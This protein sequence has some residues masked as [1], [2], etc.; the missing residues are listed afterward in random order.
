[1]I[2]I[3]FYLAGRLMDPA[4]EAKLLAFRTSNP[5]PSKAGGRVIAVM[6]IKRMLNSTRRF[7]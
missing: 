2:Q 4:A 5:P 7:R 6:R 1:M 3:V